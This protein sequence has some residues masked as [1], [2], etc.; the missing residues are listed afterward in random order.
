MMKQK[1]ILTKE[2]A[3]QI[4]N[5]WIDAWNEHDVERILSHYSF[6]IEHTT[7]IAVK[8]LGLED[9]TIIG[10]NDLRKYFN[11]ALSIALD[12][13]F[14]LIDF[15]FSVNSIAICYKSVLGRVAVEV[16]FLDQEFKIYRSIAHYNNI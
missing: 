16:L 13:K 5:E 4:V 10:R 8:L 12:L 15:Y 1:F 7:P 3:A 6:E 14:E 9:G 11:K 2:K